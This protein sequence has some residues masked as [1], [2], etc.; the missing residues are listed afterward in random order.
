MPKHIFFD[1]D[2]T[3]T[4]SRSPMEPAHQ[5]LFEKL[6]GGKDV[7]VVTGGSAEQIREQVTSRFDGKYYVL[8]QSGNDARTKN[9]APLWIEE[10]STKQTAAIKAFVSLLRREDFHGYPLEEENRGAQ[11]TASVTGFHADINEKYA[12]D[13][14]DKKR[15]AALARHDADVRKLRELGISVEPAG[16]TSFNFI[17]DGKHKGYNILRLLEHEGWKKEDCLYVGDALFTGGNDATVI[18]VIPTQAVK[19]PSDAFHFVETS[20]L[21]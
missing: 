4:K 15:Q 7:V 1:L 13:P 17:L 20:L 14:D 12:F 16:T 3:L 2:K 19:D 9:G 18:G 8:A 21:S 6:C 10:L 5:E 11:L